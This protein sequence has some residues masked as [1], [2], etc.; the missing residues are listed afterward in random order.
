MLSRSDRRWTLAVALLALIV[1]GWGLITR[2]PLPPSPLTSPEPGTPG[3]DVLVLDLNRAGTPQLVTVPNVGPTLARRI[4]QK[5][6][7]NGPYA[8][9]DELS[10]VRGIGSETLQ[11]L[12]Q[13]A[14][15]CG[16]LGCR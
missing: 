12:R 15:T 4:V 13:H 16:P 7:V 9:V 11:I 6:L 1:L 10:E 2:T 8:A 5:R 14:R 3:S